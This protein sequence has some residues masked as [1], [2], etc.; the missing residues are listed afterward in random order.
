[1]LCVDFGIPHVPYINPLFV[2]L[3]KSKGK[4][5]FA[6]KLSILSS[7]LEDG[8]HDSYS[9]VAIQHSFTLVIPPL[10]DGNG[11]CVG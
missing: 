6:A 7:R 10:S 9:L 3:S 4:P 8:I 2:L 1:M 5:A 11:P